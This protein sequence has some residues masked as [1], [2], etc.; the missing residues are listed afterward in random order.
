LKAF[1]PAYYTLASISTRRKEANRN[2]LGPA[3][4]FLALNPEALKKVDPSTNHPGRIWE[5]TPNPKNQRE[6]IRRIAQD[7]PEEDAYNTAIHGTSEDCI[8]QV[9]KYREAGCREFILTFVP[10]GGLWSTENLI[11]QI[12]LFSRNVL[13]RT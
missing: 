8:E 11:S 5:D 13:G 9:E 6:T 2:V 10:P 3:K 1:N 4:Y 12:R 7:I